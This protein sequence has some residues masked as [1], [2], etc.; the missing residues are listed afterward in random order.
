[1]KIAIPANS[2]VYGG[3]AVRRYV[4]N[5]IKYL[6]LIDKE[7]EYVALVI[8][9][10]KAMYSLP[11]SPENGNLR[12]VWCKIPARLLNRLWRYT[13]LLSLEFLLRG[14]VDVFHAADDFFP[15]KISAKSIFTVH[16]LA[17]VITPQFYGEEGCR[18]SRQLL[19][20]AA[21]K[22]DMFIAVSEN[23]KREFVNAFKVPAERVKA[24]PLGVGEEFRRFE[25]RKV[26]QNNLKERF[27]LENPYLLYLGA[28]GRHKNVEALVDAYKMLCEQKQID[29]LLVLA[30]PCETDEYCQMLR[31]K[32]AEYHLED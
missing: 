21:D 20:D 19:Q 29:H 24:I 6:P 18:R 17:K 28:L 23:V 27:G 4:L 1:M 9:T 8:G 32:I 7:N 15:P 10:G 12:Y 25:N 31:K 26:V 16:S 11:P 14:N 30:G 2:I 22:F 13:S 3:R 5:L